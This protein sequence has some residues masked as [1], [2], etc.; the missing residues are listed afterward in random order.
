VLHHA[1]TEACCSAAHTLTRNTGTKRVVARH[2][3]AVCSTGPIGINC[4]APSCKYLDTWHEH[5]TRLCKELGAKLSLLSL[6][7]T[8]DL[9]SMLKMVMCTCDVPH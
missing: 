7:N 4:S 9:R 8:D 3:I 5:V 1:W 6:A 2:V